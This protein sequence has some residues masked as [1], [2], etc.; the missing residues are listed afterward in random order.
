MSE[1]A[2]RPVQAPRRR[3]IPELDPESLPDPQQPTTK[4]ADEQPRIDRLATS[5]FQRLWE[6]TPLKSDETVVTLTLNPLL[7]LGDLTDDMNAWRAVVALTRTA[8]VFVL[9]QEDVDAVMESMREEVVEVPAEVDAEAEGPEAFAPGA[10]EGVVR[11]EAARSD[12]IAGTLHDPDAHPYDFIDLPPLPYPRMAVEVV[13]PQGFPAAIYASRPAGQGGN[14]PLMI[15]NETEPGVR[16]DVFFPS[17]EPRGESELWNFQIRS[18]GGFTVPATILRPDNPVEGKP[19]EVEASTVT[20][21][22]APKTAR[23]WRRL[24]LDLIS[25]ILA[26]NV[27]HETVHVYRQQRRQIER[28]VDPKKKGYR[29]PTIYWVRLSHS[30][31]RKEGASARALSV[32]FLV[33]GHWRQYGKGTILVNK[34]GKQH[35]RTMGGKRVWVKPHIKGPVGSPW[36]GRP[37]YRGNAVERGDPDPS[38]VVR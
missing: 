28:Q 6:G 8:T 25:L 22:T 23:F 7:G 13:T 36:K 3:D 15:V 10:E 12:D 32:R 2:A 5:Y 18:G 19:E 29:F 37:V 1:Q 21:Q 4:K 14:H 35:E 33:R 26:E 24:T 20:E 9:D 11:I 31:D 17:V 27:P 16:W 38:A 34:G 30:G